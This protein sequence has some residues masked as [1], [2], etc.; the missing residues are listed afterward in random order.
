VALPVILWFEFAS[1]Y[2][3]PAVMGAEEM[4]RDSGVALRWRPLL[5]G[6]IFKAHGMETS[7]FILNPVKGAY[8]WRDLERICADAG[9]PFRRPGRFPRGSLLA[10]RIACAF[11]EAPWIGGFIRAIY[12]ANFAEDAEIDDPTVIARLLEELGQ[13]PAAVI[14]AATTPKAKAALRAQ[15]GAALDRGIFGAPSF[16]VGDELFWGHDRMAAAF[17]WARRA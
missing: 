6:P 7:P 8:M 14:A 11:A 5:L 12:T 13:D 17:D 10:A 1:T 16:E 15:T 2:S 4:A 9:L 3:Y